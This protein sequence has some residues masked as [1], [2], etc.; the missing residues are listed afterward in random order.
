MTESPEREVIP[1]GEQPM[2]GYRHLFPIAKF[3]IEERGH[4]PIENPDRYGYV[5]TLDG[6]KFRF[7]RR[8]TDEDWAAINERF[9]MPKNIGFFH[10]LMRD[11]DNHIDMMGFDTI[12]S[13]GGEIPA[14]VWEE[15]QRAKRGG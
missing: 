13:V 1:A 4:M 11:N 9:V 8:I 5:Y 2:P 10:G 14:E 12:I 6:A 3:L 15:R 7:T